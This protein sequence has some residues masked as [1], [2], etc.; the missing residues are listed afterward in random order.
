MKKIISTVLAAALLLTLCV[1]ASAESFIFGGSSW[2]DQENTQNPV[3]V[4]KAATAVVHDGIIAEG[5]YENAGIC[6]DEDGACFLHIV[7][8]TPEVFPFAEAMLPTVE[9]YFSWSDT[10]LNLAVRAKL[11]VKDEAG[12]PVPGISQLLSPG[13]GDPPGDD[14]LFGGAGLNIFFGEF[15]TPSWF[16]YSISKNSETGEYMEGHYGQLGLT[17]AYNP[18]P[19]TDYAIDYDFATSYVTYEWSVPITSFLDHAPAAGDE[20]KGSIGVMGG[21]GDDKEHTSYGVSLGDDGF[22]VAGRNRIGSATFVLSDETVGGNGGGETTAPGT[23]EPVPTE[24]NERGEPV[25]TETNER[26][27][28]VPVPTE[29]NERGE[30]VPVTPVNPGNGGKAP[31]TG[32]PMIIL[33]A[34]TAIGAAGA[35]FISKKRK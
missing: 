28:P 10:N 34:V 18:E 15:N 33:A 26:G 27:E 1:A 35:A 6:T 22:M 12:N 24:T 14:F 32:D 20:F 21:F 9:Y 17:G 29:T 7:Y 25:P 11:F 23:T 31:G 30:P 16:Y 19:G 5:E 2:T 4:K 8:F 13:A 3:T